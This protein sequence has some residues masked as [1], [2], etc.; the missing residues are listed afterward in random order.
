M[1]SN[2]VVIN[3]TA[4]TA[5]AKRSLDSINDRVKSMRGPLLGVTAAFVG[6]G[7]VAIKAASDLSEEM[8]KNEVIFGRS[9]KIIKDFASTSATSF[10]ISKRNAME[11]A[12]T[13]GNIF[14]NAGMAR[15]AS[16]E[17]A[18]GIII[19]SADLG[20]FNNLPTAQV[21]HA[22]TSALLGEREGL[23]KLGI[24][25][26]EA[27]IKQSAMNNGIATGEDALTT[28]EKI[29]ATYELLLD[30][31]EVAQGDFA[32][33]SD[34]LANSF[35]AITAKVDDVVTAMGE[36]LL[37]VAEDLS[38]SL[39]GI[40]QALGELDPKT[41][42]TIVKI[43]A[44]TA[45]ITAT[46]LGLG[47]AFSAA[48]KITAVFK[49][50]GAGAAIV[51]TALGLPVI[52]L[53]AIGAAVGL[54][55]FAIAKNWDNF[56]KMIV[57]YADLMLA[58]FEGVTAMLGKF[59]NGFQQSV[60]GVMN[61]LIEKFNKVL[62]FFDQKKIK[63]N[64][65]FGEGMGGFLTDVSQGIAGL[66]NKLRN[67]P[68]MSGFDFA[69][70]PSGRKDLNQFMPGGRDQFTGATP[71][72]SMMPPTPVQEFIPAGRGKTN[73]PTV[74]IQGNFDHLAYLESA[75][76]Y[77]LQMQ[78]AIN[79]EKLFA[80][81]SGA[82]VADFYKLSGG[83]TATDFLGPKPTMADFSTIGQTGASPI[84]INFHGDVYGLEDFKEQ[85]GRAVTEIS[86]QGGGAMPGG[87]Q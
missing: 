82:G 43:A 19:L 69:Q 65:D 51:A 60:A 41:V 11:Y 31:T 33:T 34:G 17:L 53:M 28:M 70:G 84:Q 87:R 10:G 78:N 22:I 48:L 77:D 62:G 18:K 36:N 13:L 3:V 56:R 42:S 76:S 20:S 81:L 61:W 57:N 23:K 44:L 50:L 72:P 8:S 38:A 12:G 46:I 35:K 25:L 1:A 37:P 32:R 52:A 5:K 16:A 83:K 66:R 86:M 30:R 63:F 26:D 2:E 29:M 75:K 7:A 24:A 68:L 14:V 55:V 79:Q 6:F 67:M 64:I 71:V 80:K 15:Q 39:V 54:V 21:V 4:D 9:V 40:V 74:G 47:L 85:V 58:A 27:S 59:V 49:V 73:V 45:S